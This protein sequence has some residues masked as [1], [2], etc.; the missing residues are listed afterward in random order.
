MA[1]LALLV[2]R[3]TIQ[4]V[5]DSLAHSSPEQRSYAVEV[6]DIQLP[7]ALKPL[8]LPLVEEHSPENRLQRLQA[9]FPQERQPLVTRL[10]EMAAA[11]DERSYRWSRVCALYVLGELHMSGGDSVAPLVAALRSADPLLQETAA[12]ALSRLDDETIDACRLLLGEAISADSSELLGQFHVSQPSGEPMLSTIEKLII[13]KD[14]QLFADT[15][16]EIL[17]D[18]AQLADEIRVEAGEPVFAKGDKGDC[19]FVVA[20]GEV[21]VHDQGRTLNRLGPGQVFGEMALLDPEPRMASVTAVDDTQLLRLDQ[22]PFFELLEDRIEVTR[23]IIRVST[24]RFA[25]TWIV[26][27]NRDLPLCCETIV[28]WERR[29]N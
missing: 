20:A 21:H 5:R 28:F 3:Q 23:G 4:L 25:R 19:M 12:R 27:Q 1:L 8:V 16:D 29:S 7:T 17:A 15:P 10:Q 13:L 22:E 11:V 9:I 6:L 26:S 24:A 14:A 18:V 2:D